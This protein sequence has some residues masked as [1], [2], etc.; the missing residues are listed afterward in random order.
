MS[1]VRSRDTKPEIIV[2][3]AL[4]RQ[5]YRFRL[6][7][8]KLP[9][10]PD[11]VLPRYRTAVFVNGCFWHGHDCRRGKL[12]STNAAFWIKKIE[13]NR[14]RDCINIRKLEREAWRVHIIWE[15]DMEPGLERLLS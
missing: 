12:P 10:K 1:R 3:S 4:H 6:H 15:C 7:V 11:I 14:E 2:R 13:R 9:G 5:G 8:A